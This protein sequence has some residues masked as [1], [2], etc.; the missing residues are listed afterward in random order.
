MPIVQKK[1]LLQMFL[2]FCH[3]RYYFRVRMVHCIASKILLYCAV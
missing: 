2:C 3:H 1:L